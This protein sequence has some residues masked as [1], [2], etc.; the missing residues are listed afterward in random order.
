M[1]KI[2]LGDQQA[3]IEAG[4]LVSYKV[5]DHEFIHQKGSPGWGSS[6]TEMFP[7]I[8][9]VDQAGF[10]VQTDKGKAIQDQHGLLR[11]FP[12]D[13]VASDGVSAQFEKR[14]KANTPIKNSKFPKKSTEEWLYWP[15]DFLFT[16]T[17]RITD[18]GLEISF[19]VSGEMGMPFMLG[20][21]P[22]FKIHTKAPIIK[23]KNR[24]IA[25]AEVLAAGSRA[26]EVAH[27]NEISLIDKANIT[28][29]TEGFGHFM[30]WTEV[31]NMLCLEPITFYPYQLKQEELHKG[32]R[33]L[34]TNSAHKV[35]FSV[36]Q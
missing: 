19:E 32:F 11:Q 36:K 7:I 20:Y 22:A 28:L 8:G 23:T 4:E 21:H 26:L 1:I 33:H 35:T 16:K 25:L 12:Y 10:T 18:E 17:F 5:T 34:N 6:D 29:R 30:C 13:L 27:C 24:S 14:Y 2:R 9:P 31:D 15:Y 3:G